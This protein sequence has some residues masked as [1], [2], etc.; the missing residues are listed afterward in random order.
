MRKKRKEWGK[1]GKQDS[2]ASASQQATGDTTGHQAGGFT[3]HMET[4][5]G[6][7]EKLGLREQSVGEEKKGSLFANS[8]AEKG[9]R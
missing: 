7:K 5:M 1:E 8:R 3:A 6:C 4:Q 9:V 2:V